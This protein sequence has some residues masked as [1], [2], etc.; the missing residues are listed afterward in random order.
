LSVVR[1]PLAVRLRPKLIAVVPAGT[2]GVVQAAVDQ[3]LEAGKLDIPGPPV[4]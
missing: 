3:V 1:V 2:T 4:Q